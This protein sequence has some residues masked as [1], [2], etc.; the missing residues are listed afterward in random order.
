MSSIEADNDLVQMYALFPTV[1]PDAAGVALTTARQCTDVRI[2]W[3]LVG[4]SSCV[5][6]F[7]DIPDVCVLE[8]EIVTGQPSVVADVNAAFFHL[9]TTEK[10]S[11][12]TIIGYWSDDFV[13][14]SR[15]AEKILSQLMSRPDIGILQPSDA[16]SN[17]NRN[18]G[19]AT[20]PFGRFWWWKTRYNGSFFC[21][22][23]KRFVCDVE[24]A[25][26]AMQHNEYLYAP[27]IV[28]QHNHWITRRRSQDQWDVIGES[29]HQ[30]DKATYAARKAAGF[31]VDW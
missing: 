28:I 15:W 30:R 18:V 6:R 7:V 20:I 29:V 10:I 25:D 5:R 9:Q 3:I 26:V 8:R 4:P 14:E 21:P 22:H 27:E 12:S 23:Y 2:K 11:D 24:L 16:L 19:C 17:A 1:R 13:P 31:P